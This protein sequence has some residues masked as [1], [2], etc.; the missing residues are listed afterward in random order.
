M[1]IDVRLIDI[2]SR[3][4]LKMSRQQVEATK[5]GLEPVAA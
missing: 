2:H 4:S 1:P 3:L 5:G